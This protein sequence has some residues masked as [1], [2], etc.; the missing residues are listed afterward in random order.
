MKVEC[1]ALQK[2]Q[3]CIY[4]WMRKEVHRAY[5]HTQSQN[6][7]ARWDKKKDGKNVWR[8]KKKFQRIKIMTLGNWALVPALC[9]S[10]SVVVT[11]VQF[12]MYTTR[13]QLFFRLLFSSLQFPT[14]NSIEQMILFLIK[15]VFSFYSILLD[16]HFCNS[17][18]AENY[19]NSISRK[20]EFE[21]N[22]F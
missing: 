21:N 15:L 19:M 18:Q 20:E 12:Y 9:I 17:S 8:R 1:S 11:V 4:R 2:I 10:V 6:E 13:I 3:K 22:I 16:F 14:G 7:I 5:I